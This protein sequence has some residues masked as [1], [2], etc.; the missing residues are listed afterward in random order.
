MFVYPWMASRN[1]DMFWFFCPI[2]VAIAASV[3]IQQFPSMGTGILFLLLINAF[4]VGPAHQGPT[5]FFYFDKKNREHWTADSKRIFFYFVAPVLVFVGSVL[6]QVY[7][8]FIGFLVTTAWSVQHFVQQNFGVTLLYHNRSNNEAMPDR[9][10]LLRS[11]WSPAIFFTAVFFVTW[12]NNPS[13]ITAVAG[14]M[15]A[16]LPPP[17]ALPIAMMGVLAG[18]GGLA[19]FDVT[20][21][22]LDMRRQGA[23]GARINVPAFMFWA[24]SA[25]YFV[26]FVMP[27]QRIETLW[28][29]PGTMHWF[30][31]IGLNVILVK[32]K[33][34][35][36]NRRADIPCGA[37]VL[38][39]LLCI[40][41]ALFFVA[42][43][44]YALNF[45]INSEQFRLLIG[46]Y[47]GLANVHYYQDAFFW[48]F[49]EKFQRESIM[50]YLL[51]ARNTVS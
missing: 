19:L 46:V 16:P 32:E 34:K 6:M 43:R 13:P 45:D 51:Q 26:P 48:R 35:D 5:W 23:N 42:N 41:S 12:F 9:E 2:L 15:L 18:L 21:Y 37:L 29:I 3:L 1:F 4:G 20:R 50:P 38:M 31:Y 24:A 39:A 22:I 7:L 14:G 8:P 47:F 25:L 36:P 44:A 30:Q 40:G 17:K 10:L 49:R 33:Y 28:L 11:L 27:G